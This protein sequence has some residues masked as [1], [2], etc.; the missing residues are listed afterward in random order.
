MTGVQTCALPI[1]YKLGTNNKDNILRKKIIDLLNYASIPASYLGRIDRD[2]VS[3]SISQEELN[4]VVS[5]KVNDLRF[6]IVYKGLQYTINID[7]SLLDTFTILYKNVNT[8][9]QDTI[10]ELWHK[11]R[12]KE[13]N[14]CDKTHDHFESFLKNFNRAIKTIEEYENRN[15]YDPKDGLSKFL[16]NTIEISRADYSIS[17][18]ITSD[19]KI[20]VS[21]PEFFD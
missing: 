5:I 4:Q 11:I 3:S 2:A 15:E 12:V 18:S 10:N 8:N 20:E 17:C 6:I 13:K 9:D 7:K 16:K 14:K 1:F 19:I 21:P